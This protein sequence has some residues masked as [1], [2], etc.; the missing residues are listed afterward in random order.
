MADDA[1]SSATLG[2]IMDDA[3]KFATPFAT[4][5]LGTASTPNQVQ[6]ERLRDAALNGGGPNDPT[7]ANQSPL[8]LWDFIL[9]KRGATEGTEGGQ[10]SLSSKGG[11]NMTTIVI[12]VVAIIAVFV[13]LK[14]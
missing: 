3:L 1:A 14:K 7:L 11:L 8:G 13:I 10:S 4:R 2:S 12:A 9:G 5:L 6:A